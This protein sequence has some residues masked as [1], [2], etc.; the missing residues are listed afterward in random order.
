MEQLRQSLLSAYDPE[1]VGSVTFDTFKLGLDDAEHNNLSVRLVALVSDCGDYL[2]SEFN[3]L[4]MSLHLQ[5]TD[6]VSPTASVQFDSDGMVLSELS[7]MEQTA[8]S[9]IQSLLEELETLQ[10]AAQDS[11]ESMTT[12]CSLLASTHPRLCVRVCVLF[13]SHMA[14][15]ARRQSYTAS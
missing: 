4:R 12:M 10:G 14:L 1:G 11:E 15:P 13:Y 3:K 8:Q 9:V 7:V 2:Y 5:S 6:D